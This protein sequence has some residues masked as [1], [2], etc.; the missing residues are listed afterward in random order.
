MQRFLRYLLS[1][2]LVVLAIGCSH[3]DTP[4]GPDNQDPTALLKPGDA[5][6]GQY[7]VVFDNVVP[8][9]QVPS[10]A[11]DMGRTHAATVGH[12]YSS[13]IHGFSA[14]MSS[15]Q[16]A[17]L[18]ND[19]RVKY[20]EPDRVIALAPPPGKGKPGG[21]DGGGGGAPAQETPWGVADVGGTGTFDEQITVWI[22]DTGLDLDHPD[23][24]VDQTRSRNF[25]S[26]G[27]DSPNDGNG[28]GTH[29]GGT[30]GAIDNTFGV[31][32]IAPG[33]TLVAVRV[34][35]NNG[36]G[37]YS[38]VIA[39]VDYVAANGAAGDVANMSLGGPVST[40]LDNA[41]AACGAAGIRMAIAAGND[42]D[43]ASNYSPS[44]VNGTNIYTVSAHDQSGCL[45][46][47]SN[48]GNSTN[49]SPVDFA[50]P[51]L[52]ILSTWKGGGYNTISGTSMATPHVAGLLV[53]GALNSQGTAC[54]DPDG[55][56]DP[57]AHQ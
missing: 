16:A 6:P 50:A 27:K 53:L 42:G 21:G 31:V 23:L 56:A 28:H 35:D 32:G 36:S 10:V 14:R 46:S 57:L 29:V 12:V 1:T 34:L 20:V 52:N 38:D 44:R 41:V 11:S 49:G 19:P 17:A 33:V 18:A 55:F 7:I 15:A 37:S 30:I 22:I 47:W 40:A 2:M 26:R 54:N 48:Y 25:V 8:Q 45:T 9:S 43:D 4:F 51:G 13:S 5:I 39:G 24:N 3:D